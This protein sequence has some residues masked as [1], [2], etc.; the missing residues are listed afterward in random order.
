MLKKT[1]VPSIFS[2]SNTKS[3]QRTT[4]TSQRARTEIRVPVN[5]QP[6]EDSL[7]LIDNFEISDQ[8]VEDINDPGSATMWDSINELVYVCAML[9][10]FSPPLVC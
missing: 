6:A 2:W 1:A 5:Q 7:T 4:R 8:T 3:S 9:C 10:N